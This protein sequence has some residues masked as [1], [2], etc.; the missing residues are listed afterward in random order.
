MY[1]DNEGLVP[2]SIIEKARKGDWSAMEQIIDRYRYLI[3]HYAKSDYAR[4]EAED[5]L[6]RT[7]FRFRIR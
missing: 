1:E 2:F 4:M 6:I 5:E 3:W 7:I